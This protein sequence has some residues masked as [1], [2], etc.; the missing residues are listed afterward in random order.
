M[1]YAKTDSSI[2]II[3]ITTL[4]MM[5]IDIAVLTQMHFQSQICWK[6]YQLKSQN[7]FCKS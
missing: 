7:I 3:S 5:L 4:T 6:L 2:V 1:L